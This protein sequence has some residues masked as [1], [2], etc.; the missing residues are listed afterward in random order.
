MLLPLPPARKA[1]RCIQSGW[2]CCAE[3]I[4][5]CCTMKRGVHHMASVLWDPRTRWI[6]LLACTRMPA[7]ASM[8]HLACTLSDSAN[9]FSLSGSAPRPRGSK[10][11]DSHISVSALLSTLHHYGFD[12]R[13]CLGQHLWALQH[14]KS[15][16]KSPGRLPSKCAGGSPPVHQRQ[17]GKHRSVVA[18]SFPKLS[19]A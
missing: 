5:T 3:L 6:S 12:T 2:A 17:G 13:T 15:Y 7:T 8:A 18:H 10:L 11:H 4:Y 14:D 19:G 16:P 9:H 1:L